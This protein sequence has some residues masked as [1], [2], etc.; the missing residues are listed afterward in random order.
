MKSDMTN[1]SNSSYYIVYT[2]DQQRVHPCKI[3]IEE[4]YQCLSLFEIEDKTSNFLFNITQ[5]VL[6]TYQTR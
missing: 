3:G 2:V 6:A 5:L 1:K 4:T